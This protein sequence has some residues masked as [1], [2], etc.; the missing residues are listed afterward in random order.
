MK[1][2]ITMALIST[3]ALWGFRLFSTSF[4]KQNLFKSFENPELTSISLNT[5]TSE[6]GIYIYPNTFNKKTTPLQSTL[7]SA[8]VYCLI[9]KTNSPSPFQEAYVFLISFF[10]SFLMGWIL[11]LL[12]SPSFF[13]TLLISGTIGT[14]IGLYRLLYEWAFF[15][16]PLPYITLSVTD[17]IL[18]LLI[19]GT[20]L[21]LSGKFKLFSPSSSI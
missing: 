2:L 16:P 6:P 17:S 4:F 15:T 20:C 11:S 13:N 3:F 9:N 1:K 14:I 8:R 18:S 7:N 10:I 12:K 19:V 21:H 5:Q